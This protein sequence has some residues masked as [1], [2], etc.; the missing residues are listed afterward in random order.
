MRLSIGIE[1]GLYSN[2]CCFEP[3]QTP[4]SNVLLA[5]H[6][7]SHTPSIPNLIDPFPSQWP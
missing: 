6:V 2:D 1:L 7:K 3:P 5:F 4:R